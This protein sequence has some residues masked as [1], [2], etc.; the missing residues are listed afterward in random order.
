VAAPLEGTDEEQ[1]LLGGDAGEDGDGVGE[2]GDAVE[3]GGGR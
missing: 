2:L 3:G 1:L